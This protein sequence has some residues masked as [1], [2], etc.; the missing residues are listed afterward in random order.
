MIGGCR[1][2]NTFT[3]L[4]MD[5]TLVQTAKEYARRHPKTQ[6][7]TVRQACAQKCAR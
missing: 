2:R 4:D 1:I 7:E 5:E 3:G 6:G